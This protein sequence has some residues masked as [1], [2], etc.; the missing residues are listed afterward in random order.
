MKNEGFW[1]QNIEFDSLLVTCDG[2]ELRFASL[3]AGQFV[4]QEQCGDGSTHAQVFGE[5][6][7]KLIG[8]F[9]SEEKDVPADVSSCESLN[10]LLL[11]KIVGEENELLRAKRKNLLKYLYAELADEDET[12]SPIPLTELSRA[13]EMITFLSSNINEDVLKVYKACLLGLQERSS[14]PYLESLFKTVFSDA[15]DYIPETSAH[16]MTTLVWFQHTLQEKI[17]GGLQYCKQSEGGVVVFFGSLVAT[18]TEFL[19]RLFELRVKKPCDSGSSKDSAVNDQILQHMEHAI[20]NKHVIWVFV[21]AGLAIFEAVLAAHGDGSNG[22]KVVQHALALV[23]FNFQILN[24]SRAENLQKDSSQ[25]RLLDESLV[26]LCRLSCSGS[27]NTHSCNPSTQQL[28]HVEQLLSPASS[29]VLWRLSET[30]W[31]DLLGH[32]ATSQYPN[33]LECLYS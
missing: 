16:K 21:D 30:L 9:N 6:V 12:S 2:R 28:Q 27:A 23:A 18:W 20:M 29:S 15:P 22:H 24:E 25:R 19:T 33:A 10:A 17:L 11:E 1:M 7:L 32:D 31:R 13:Q 14:C 5:F 8:A 3:D 26:G 4:D